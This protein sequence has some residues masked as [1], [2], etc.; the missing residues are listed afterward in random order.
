MAAPHVSGALAVLRSAGFGP[1]EAVERLLSTAHDLGPPGPDGTFGAGRVDLGAAL[2][3][4]APTGQP[5]RAADSGGS[6]GTDVPASTTTS[7]TPA[8]SAGG[9]PPASTT[10]STTP[11]PAVAPP[12]TADP[13]PS[14]ELGD[15]EATDP[16]SVAPGDRVPGLLASVAVLCVVAVSA[17]H[18]WRYLS[19]ATWARRTPQ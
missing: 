16:R 6:A 12:P 3:G 15:E 4:V 14:V 2:A 19:T 7:T 8:P 17:G 5:V 9:A 11:A 10:T 13:A 18:A 1:Q